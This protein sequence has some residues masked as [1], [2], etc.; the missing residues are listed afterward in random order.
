MD[1]F[2]STTSGGHRTILERCVEPGDE[3]VL[4]APWEQGNLML[5]RRRLVVTRKAGMLRR[6]SM[7][8]N[9]T[10]AHLSNVSWN[11]D[12]R[13]RL[14]VSL[15]AIDGVR[16]RFVL[17]LASPDQVREA[18]ECLRSVVSPRREDFAAAA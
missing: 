12:A 11:V 1:V 7:H 2:N 15:T 13:N 9:A 17:R 5:T 10:F 16:E 8:L 18:E 6:K 14:E 4:V 3:A